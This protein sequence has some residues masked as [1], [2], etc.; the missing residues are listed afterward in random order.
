MRL[1]LLLFL[2][3]LTGCATTRTP[4]SELVGLGVRPL[5]PALN[6]SVS[7]VLREEF[8]FVQRGGQGILGDMTFRLL[9]G[10]YVEHG[11]D[12]LGTFY[13]HAT[14]GVVRSGNLGIAE[15]GGFYV[16]HDASGRWGIWI[17]PKGNDVA[18]GL[19]GAIGAAIPTP[20][21]K[22]NA[23]YCSNITVEE[24]ARF[25][26]ILQRKSRSSP[27]SQL[28]GADAPLRG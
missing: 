14:K 20:D 8:V 16:P 27:H 11:S 4:D 22:L 28:R 3:L 26:S 1:S 7:Y 2:A 25:E 6:A 12:A 23:F 19:F 9:P 18:I 17:V 21:R 24:V 10:E 13:R 5:T 15:A